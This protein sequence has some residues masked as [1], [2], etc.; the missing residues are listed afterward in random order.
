MN[1]RFFIK[2]CLILLQLPIKNVEASKTTLFLGDVNVVVLTDVHSWIGGHG[3]HEPELNAD[4]GSVLSFYERLKDICK[5]ENKDLFFVMNGD[6]MDGT[7]LTTHPPKL[8]TSILQQMPWDALNIG[9]HELYL[10]STIEYISEKDGFVD[11]WGGAYLTSNVILRETKETIGKR[12]TF[13]RG[14]FKS[15]LTFGFLYDMTDNCAN[16]EVE[17]VENVLNSAWFTKA[18]NGTE[19]EFDAI[20][21][22]AHMDVVDPLVKIILDRIRLICGND[23]PV[24][25]I[26][27]HTHIRSYQVLDSHSTSFE[28]GRYL[29]TVGFVSFPIRNKMNTVDQRAKTVENIFYHNF[30]EGNVSSLKRTLNVDV[31]ET[32]SGRDLTAQIT[33]AQEELGLFEIVGCCPMTY[34]FDSH[35]G[36][37][38]SLW[39]LFM[40]DV[41]PDQLFQGG[42]SKLFISNQGVIRY[43]LFKGNVTVADLIA[44]S[45]FN[46]TIF[47]I[48]EG[49]IGTQFNE[50]F[51]EFPYMVLWNQ[52]VEPNGIYTVYSDDF[53]VDFVVKQLE[54][55]TGR[56]FSPSKQNQSV[57]TLWHGYVKS[58]WQCDNEVKEK[59]ESVFFK[60]VGTSFLWVVK[61]LGFVVTYCATI[62]HFFLF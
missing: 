34:H 44:V 60:F 50:A 41:I 61:E 48:G 62:F 14:S 40:K 46:G 27:G 56:N 18:L 21:V 57:G 30:I 7:G 59:A 29:D 15:I 6:F 10:N 16:T 52:T 38:D 51:R 12:F 39:E 49:I 19:G 5:Q 53:D 42:T 24:Q 13:L 1:M 26:T 55:V 36:N 8:L 47:E 4:Y 17:T 54:N 23:M 11:K 43:N 35:F 58:K 25:F 2:L 22:L 33:K 37:E 45:P 28:A 31:L 3:Y 9:N 32:S 20:L